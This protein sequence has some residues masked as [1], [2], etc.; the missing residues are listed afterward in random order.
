MKKLILVSC[1]SLLLTG[2]TTG[3]ANIDDW[4]ITV[5]ASSTPHAQILEQTKSYIESKGYK[6][7]IKVMNDYVTPNISLRDGDL[8]A[9]Y[10]QHE[11][12]LKEFNENYQTDIV[13]AGKVHFEPMTI[14]AGGKISSRKIVIPN[15]KSNND[16]ARA[17]LESKKSKIALDLSVY[18]FIEAEASTIPM[19]REDVSYI[20]VNGNYALES[21]L[22]EVATSIAREDTEDE[23]AQKMANIIAVR[24]GSENKPAISVLLESL[25]Q[26]NVKSFILEKY[27]GAVIPMF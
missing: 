15:D 12:Y 9:N 21:G 10:F 1:V 13:S 11:P 18:E 6:L 24:K 26:D 14:F 3:K 25:K 23:I 4:T 27:K 19:L 17:L 8:D 7:D 20:V 22:F 5:G 2:C 16:R